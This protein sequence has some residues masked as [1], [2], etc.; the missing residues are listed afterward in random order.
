MNGYIAS[1]LLYAVWRPSSYTYGRQVVK[2]CDLK[3]NV[4]LTNGL[5]KVMLHGMTFVLTL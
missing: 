1:S 5:L 3:E 4:L 2:I